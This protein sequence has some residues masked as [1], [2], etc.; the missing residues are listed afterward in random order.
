MVGRLLYSKGYCEYVDAAKAIRMIHPEVEFSIAGFIDSG[1]PDGIPKERVEKD[2]QNGYIKYL[3][4][5]DNIVELLEQTDL[6]VLPSFYNEGMN[7]SLMEAISMGKVVISTDN[8]GCREMVIDGVNGYLV[9]PK[10]TDGLI[11]A[12]DKVLTLSSEEF[13]KM[14]IHSR[15]LAE[16]RFSDKKVIEIY[17]RIINQ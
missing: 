14:R 10:D 4:T 3:G 6:F 1:H 8:K 5:T 2:V 7:R 13:Y 12:I 15:K 11:K 17:K 16:D 9:Q